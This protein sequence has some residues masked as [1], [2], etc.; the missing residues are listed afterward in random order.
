MWLSFKEVLFCQWDEVFLIVGKDGV[1]DLC[2]VCQLFGIIQSTTF[3]FI[4]VPG[5]VLL[6]SQ[7]LSQP[8]SHVFVQQKSNR[9]HGCL[10]MMRASQ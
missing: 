4:Y 9:A 2:G 3:E 5:I 6:L 7:R 8:W 10:R 1:A